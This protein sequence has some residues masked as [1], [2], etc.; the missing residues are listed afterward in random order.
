MDKGIIPKEVLLK[1]TKGANEKQ[2]ILVADSKV[3]KE[4]REEFIN[5]SKT[6]HLGWGILNYDDSKQIET[7]ILKALKEQKEDI[8]KKIDRMKES[9]EEND[10][11]PYDQPQ[12]RAYNK[13]IEDFKNLLK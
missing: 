12:P 4:F 11:A 7:F 5:G 13:S 9:G 1:A 2:A 3:I 8:L 10:K 6:F